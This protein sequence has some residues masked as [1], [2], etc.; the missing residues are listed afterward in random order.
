MLRVL[1]VL[2]AVVSLAACA[3]LAGESRAQSG[4]A[5]WGQLVFDSRVH[6]EA[7][8]QLSASSSATL[9][10]RADGT[11]VAWGLNDR[12]ACQVPTS[13]PGLSFVEAQ[14]GFR[15]SVARR[16]DGVLVTWGEISSTP[17]VAPPGLSFT[18]IDA[19]G[20][21]GLALRS[22]GTIAVWG[23]LASAPA[24]PSGTTYVDL[25]AGSS[26]ALAVRSDGVVVGWGSNTSGQCNMPAPPPGLVYVAVSANYAYSLGLL[27]DGTIASCG[28]APGSAPALPPGLSYT[29]IAAGGLHALA[30]RSDGAVVGWGSNVQHQC[31]VPTLPPGTRYVLVDAADW[32]SVALR[33]DGRA[34]CWGDNTRSQCNAPALPAGL[35][36]VEC[37]AH[38]TNCEVPGSG[39][40]HFAAL[41]SDGQI[42]T[43]G[44]SPS[45]AVP[46]LP[47]GM[48]YEQLSLG[49]KHG[50]ALRSDGNVMAWGMN[51]DGA[52][53][54]PPPPPGLRYVEARAGGCEWYEQCGL[55]QDFGAHELSLMRLS[56]GSLVQR[57]SCE[58]SLCVVPGDTRF[59]SLAATGIMLAAVRAD[60]GIVCWGLG[61]PAF[62]TP[63]AGTSYV[64]VSLGGGTYYETHCYQLETW[65]GALRVAR[66]SD[67]VVVWNGTGSVPAAPAGLRYVEVAA[68]FAHALARLSDGTVVAWGDNSLR[69]CNVPVPRAGTGYVALA[70]SPFQSMAIFEPLPARGSVAQVCAAGANSVS[71]AG[72]TLEAR[73]AASVSANDLALH[74]TQLPPLAIG[75]FVYGSGLQYAPFGNGHLCIAGSVQRVLP[76]QLS[77]ATGA[78][79]LAVDL[80]Q[81][82]F[83]GSANAIQPGS[84][85][86]FQYWYRDPSS[87]GAATF[88]ASDA[89]HVVFAP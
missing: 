58:F 29:A 10:L 51:Y 41:R 28:A 47:A 63:P 7:C 75:Q 23:G 30:L 78:V 11:L 68:G 33:S 86:N 74:V 35:R 3:F 56:D 42:V 39:V 81:Y 60:G 62:P 55:G 4:V 89:L 44:S 9:A 24:L 69:Q 54:I 6:E 31:E 61:S 27:S 22:D 46:D 83:S 2:S 77:S 20:N 25:A 82:P 5:G 15:I 87:P 17:P 50:I 88:N 49:P 14:S 85:W 67:G 80:A 26:H 72:A 21:F 34:V 38:N 16:S 76:L 71:S 57:G 40:G 64:E 52:C 36:Y 1:Q 48:R 32:H 73:G 18:K 45:G 8:V 43:W 84:A 59:T 12:A 53:N 65:Y 70:A 13:P 66:R 79:D 37:A 19:G